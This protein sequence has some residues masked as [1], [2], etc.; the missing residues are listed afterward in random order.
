MSRL[1]VDTQLLLWNVSGSRRLPARVARL[2]RDGR[3]QFFYS[4]ASL[5]EI[6][7]KAA[8]GRDDFVADAAAIHET[9]GE[10]GFHEL[11]VTAQHAAAVSRL[12][13]I[14]G[15]PFD[16]MLIA[17]AISE[18]MALVTTDERLAAYPATVEIV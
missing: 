6:A 17:Q 16:R 3:H 7:I 2:F 12:P 5:W 18:P 13:P 1:L 11:G 9:L 14:H 15:D 4:A 8:L 10:N